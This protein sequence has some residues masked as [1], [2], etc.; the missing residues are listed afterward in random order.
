LALRIWFVTYVLWFA[1]LLN[2]LSLGKQSRA[3]RDWA[4][5]RQAR[6]VKAVEFIW[7]PEELDAITYGPVPKQIEDKTDEVPA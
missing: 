2:M 6:R 5:R 3:A 7:D 1:D 4:L